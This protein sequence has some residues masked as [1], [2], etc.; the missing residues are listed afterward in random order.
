MFGLSKEGRAGFSYSRP[1]G[2]RGCEVSDGQLSIYPATF[3]HSYRFGYDTITSECKTCRVMTVFDF[4]G[5]T[6]K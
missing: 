6:V 3:R 2:P 5:I 4:Y 1:S